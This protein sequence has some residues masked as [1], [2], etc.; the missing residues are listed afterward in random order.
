MRY[1]VYAGILVACS[2]PA[3]WLA[4]AGSGGTGPVTALPP[5]AALDHE[6]AREEASDAEKGV[7]GWDATLATLDGASLI[8]GAD[9][10]AP[11]GSGATKQL[12]VNLRALET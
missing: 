11:E 1:G 10:P 6:K 3:L 7:G 5:G 9:A 2:L 8:G 12:L 4:A